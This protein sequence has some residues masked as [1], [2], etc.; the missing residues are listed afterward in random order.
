[1][2]YAA[3]AGYS[4]PSQYD[5]LEDLLYLQTGYIHHGFLDEV[6]PC[7]FG[8]N[9]EG[10]QSAAEWIRTAF[11]D[12]ATHD[13][14]AGSGGLDASIMFELNREE[15]PGVAFNNTLGFMNGFYNIQAST[16]DL[17]ALGVVT[18]LGTCGGPQ[19]LFRAGRIDATEAGPPGV[20]EPSQNLSSTI[21]AFDKA[22][23]NVTEMIEL[24]A[25]GHTL[26]GVH[27]VNFPEI[28]GNS[29]VGQV[30]RFEG[31][32]GTAYAKFDTTVVT[33]YLGDAN[34]NPLVVGQNDTTNSDKRVFGADG[35][36]TMEALAD[37]DTFQERC[38]I[39]LEKMI[40][41]VPAEVTLSDPIQPMEVKPYITTLALNGNGTLDFSGRIR[42][43]VSPA[44]GRNSSDMAV[45]LTYS[46]R[47]GIQAPEAIRTVQGTF[48]GGLS[49]GLFGESFTWF[50]FS[51][52]LNLTTGIS[53]IQVQMEKIS[54]GETETFDNG[55]NG[56]P[57]QDSILYQQ[58]QS[59]INTTEIN[60][61][62]NTTISAAVRRDQ[63]NRKVVLDL[64]HEIE[65]PG[66]IINSLE[67]RSMALNST[68]QVVGDY[69]L[70]EAQI[71]L[72]VGSWSTT[73][74]L[75]LDDTF[76][77]EFQQTTVL[78]EQLC[79]PL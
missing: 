63:T 27:G 62:F 35:N 67:V 20:P 37:S 14:I 75:V 30:S 49:A 1:M 44:T 22:G 28:T 11:H 68:G 39:V 34:V 18:A 79:V 66:I 56:F 21:S 72:E 70:Y 71:A 45:H 57:I 31:N 52:Q 64:V 77:V 26:G 74:D 6:N 13:A 54:S 2:F 61:A 40:N 5:Y 73:F 46:D 25:C 47:N 33:Q 38:A 12:M 59:C 24:V 36:V 78:S 51:T 60:G 7:A 4:W 19:I 65:R 50:E 29:S 53:S 76:K 8:V 9:E 69:E 23:F 43:R 10:R 16:A 55:G 58:S 41:T 48:Q 3:A 32:N 15:N 42:V 17:I